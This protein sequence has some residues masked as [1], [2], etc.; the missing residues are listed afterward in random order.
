ML[1]MRLKTR[2]KFVCILILLFAITILLPTSSPFIESE[3]EI[4]RASGPI[5]S[6]EY[7]DTTGY[8]EGVFVSG[9]YA[10]VADYDSGLAVINISDPT[11][12]GTPVYEDTTGYAIGVYVSGDYA[13]VAIYGSGLAVIDISDPTNP[14][15]P[16]YEDTTGY[17][18]VVYVSGDY[19][20]VACGSSGLAV[21]DISNPTNPGTPVYEDTTGTARGVYVS[22]DYAYV[23]DGYSGLAVIDI[24]NPTNPGTPVY[25]DTTGYALGVFVSGDYAY[26]ADHDSGL[27]V[28]DISD[29]TNPGT[30][31]YED[32]TGNAWSV[33]V[34]GDYAHVAN[35]DSGLAVIDISNPT[36]PGT[37]VYKD[38]TSYAYDVYVSGNYAYVAD[39]YTGLAIIRVAASIDPSIQANEDTTG[40]AEI[41]FVSGDYAYVADYDSGL[42]V[43][44]ISNPTN[45]GTPVYEDT[46]DYAEGVYVSGDYAYVADGSSGLA[47][48]DIS[49]P[50]NPGTPV[51][52][53]TTDYARGVYVSGDYA[54]VAVSGSG[55]AVIDISDPTNPGTPVY[56]DTTGYAI[57]VF[58]SGDYAYV[59]DHSS[60][61]AVIDISDPTNPGTPVY[62]DTTGN[63]W[64]VYVSGDYAYVAN[65]DSGLAVIDISNPTNPGTPVYEDTTGY[66]YRVY[67]SG[68]YAYVADGS[69]GLAVIDIS[70][71]TNPGTPVYEGT[72]DY[73]RG[74]YVSG[75][76]A[77]VA[78]DTS[79]LTVIQVRVTDVSAPSI[80]TSRS[81]DDP[82]N[83]DSVNVTVTATDDGIGIDKI[84]LYSRVVAV[85]TWEITE[86]VHTTG[87]DFEAVIQPEQYNDEVEYYTFAND[88]IGNSRTSSTFSYTV[89]DG[90]DPI[91]SDVL[92]SPT[93]PEY[94][95]PTTVTATVTDASSGVQFAE[96]RYRTRPL[97]GGWSEYVIIP[98][99][100]PSGDTYTEDI[101]LLA[102]GTDVEYFVLAQDNALN[103]VNTSASQ[104]SYT[105]EDRTNPV[106]SDVDHVPITPTFLQEAN[107]TATVADPGSGLNLVQIKYR[108]DPGTGWSGEIEV[109]MTHLGGG[110]YQGV[111]PI[112]AVGTQVEYYIWAQDRALH[113]SDTSASPKGYNVAAAD[114]V[115]PTVDSL[116]QDPESPIDTDV[117]T[118]TATVTDGTGVAE[119]ILSYST[120]GGSSWANVSMTS[121]AGN[122]WVASIPQQAAGTT[123]QYKIYSRDFLSNWAVSSEDS[124]LVEAPDT[125]GPNIG[126]SISPGQPTDVTSVTVTATVTDLSGVDE[127]HLDYKI[128]DASSWTTAEMAPG[129]GDTWTASIP[130]QPAGTT[131]TY[132]IRASDDLGNWAE[133]DESS[134]LV[135]DANPPPTTLD[136]FM[137]YVPLLSAVAALITLTRGFFWWKDKKA[138]KGEFSDTAESANGSLISSDGQD[139]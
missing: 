35:N 30:P 32:T 87:D 50:T 102:Y 54:Y 23:A 72:T 113:E 9:D 105:V 78:D 112:F 22:G 96:L 16:V 44:N 25:E 5:L 107:V 77:Y 83:I 51:Y 135:E 58:V 20:Y 136:I 73:A 2:T 10:Y 67:V 46:A 133:S 71:P 28:I 65:Y 132:K 6:D 52:E 15:T 85:G 3:Q 14:G 4:D 53:G 101:P 125:T 115:G 24:S 75:D 108:Y 91:I 8:A 110:V 69:S 116:E 55:L 76:Y 120:D 137:Q 92:H 29:P 124:Y 56:E 131:V 41:V 114:S 129:S 118:I 66:A 90:V 119:V 121:Q 61:L 81:P 42:A 39:G 59:A 31:V 122:E 33:Y 104:G 130:V 88:T 111:I 80:S 63:A 126:P 89:G 134:Y 68:D 26:V 11:N 128:D 45:P 34:S 19:A 84:M 99:E 43:I 97:D 100:N 36:N 49:N 95:E 1:D 86:M 37:P 60:G 103:R 62:E 38:T 93:N 98:M 139:D 40:Y 127:V 21:I 70:D 12:P 48:I 106:I 94:T 27:A 17:A 47:V 57:G 117:V 109:D 13:Y 138:K 123:V 74:V 18:T 82:T 64:G 79:G 7:V